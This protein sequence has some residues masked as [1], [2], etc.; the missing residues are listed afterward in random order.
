MEERIPKCNTDFRKEGQDQFFLYIHDKVDT[1]HSVITYPHSHNSYFLSFLY[2]GTMQ[3]FVDLENSTISAPALLVLTID[4]VHI[5]AKLDKDCKVITMAFSSEFIYRQNR[6]LT[7]YMETVF[8]QPFLQ[9]SAND[10]SELDKYI[11]LIC[12]ENNKGKD[13]NIEIINYL[14]NIILIQCANLSE[15]IKKNTSYKNDLF[16]DFK[17][18]LNKFYRT[19]HTV[20]FYADQLNITTS[21]LT[22]IVK[23]VSNKTPKQI[24]DERLLIEAKRLL[25]W[26]DITVREV[27]W[28]LGFETDGYFIRFF[29]KFTGITPGD[30]QKVMQ[31]D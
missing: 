23:R 10:L 16:L 4:Q 20:K 31:V 13:K 29:K 12:L 26:S 5:D 17:D 3:H 25:Y 2:E 15:K 7:N 30:F 22:E 9:L 24:I 11:Q 1:D 14:V 18:C 27:A 8:S 19:N 28:E 6:K 21:V